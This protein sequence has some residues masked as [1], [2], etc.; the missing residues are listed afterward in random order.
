MA[1][2]HLR[3]RRQRKLTRAR[4]IARLL[5]LAVATLSLQGIFVSTER[6]EVGGAA[7][8]LGVYAW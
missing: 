7:L 8:H 2:G 5:P 1:G 6:D 4:G 3:Q